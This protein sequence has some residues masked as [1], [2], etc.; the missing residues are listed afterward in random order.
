MNCATILILEDASPA[1]S[2]H[3]DLIR[4]FVN[5]FFYPLAVIE[6]SNMPK[7]DLIA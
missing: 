2:R 7:H 6:A 1:Q 4:S 5:V 3:E